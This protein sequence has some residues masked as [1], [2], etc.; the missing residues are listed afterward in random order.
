MTAAALGHSFDA[1]HAALRRPATLAPR[2]F[3]LAL[4][5]MVLAP[6]ASLVGIAWQGD[7]EIWPHL[8]AYVLPAALADTALLLAGVAVAT[9]LTGVGTAWLVTAYQ[10]P[11]RDTL[12]WL[13]PL[14]LAF[15]TYIVAYVYVD[16]LDAAGPVQ[17]VFR[18]LFGYQT[19]A[20]Y[21]FPPIR[22]LP[23]A[24]LLIGVVL[25][26]Y[27]YL[28]ARAMFQTQSAALIEVART[29]GASP[30]MLV[31][32][33]ALPLAR[34]ALAVGLSLV[35]LETLNDIGASEYLGVRTLTLSIFTTWLNRGSLPGAAQI[36]CVMLV[37]VIALM[38][39][40]RHGR[41]HRRFAASARRHRPLARI[42]L[43]GGARLIACALCLAPVMVGFVLPLIFLL[44]ETI[45]RGLLFGLDPD[46]PRHA[47]M[48]V[49]LAGAATLVAI[50]LGL[51][52]ALA[53]RHVRGRLAGGCLMIAGLG[54]AVPGT[55]LAL[56]LLAPLVA[57]DEGL[58]WLTRA[59]AGIS[60]GL[61]LAGSGAALIIAYVIRFLAIA[62]GSA[63]AG[64]ARIPTQM[65]DV[66]RT[67]GEKP[68]GIA[69]RIHLPLSRA[70]LGGAALLVFVDCLKELPATLLLRPLNV[71]TLPTY[72]YQ[73]ATR[74]NFEDG[75]LAAL[76]IVAAGIIPVLRLT[77]FAD[78]A[79][80]AGTN[81]S[82]GR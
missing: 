50:A 79:P 34:P 5:A 26:P 22:S 41:R 10:F 9:A 82:S 1:L 17:T 40:E 28:A 49:L 68:A 67:L 51:A 69:W 42:P 58:N 36:A 21:W 54:Y 48:T 37:G 19:A 32:H 46:L 43:S 52:A 65:D 80:A 39:L 47:V 30:L 18:A 77:R 70:A 53:V 31:R 66:A 27:V 38:A 11:G 56:G 33:V 13:L 74:G 76:L 78:I 8:A 60:V 55:V 4:A 44:R 45:V 35:L 59:L 12:V 57:V 7:P 81:G 61:V 23:G 2:L 63:Q 25:Y 3:L 29:L 14:P 16:M 75:A 6:L 15:P 72:I 20:Q 64:L 73:F 62:T 24:I 71:E